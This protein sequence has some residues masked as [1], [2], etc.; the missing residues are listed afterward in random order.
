MDY[1][2]VYNQI[3]D[4]RQ[5][6]DRDLIQLLL[7]VCGER[8]ST[9][10]WCSIDGA[11][12]CLFLLSKNECLA[13]LNG[14]ESSSLAGGAFE[15]KSNL[16]GSLCLLSEDGLGLTSETFLLGIISSLTLSNSRGLTGLVLGNLVNG[17]FVAFRAVSS[18][19]FGSVYLKT[20]LDKL[21]V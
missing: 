18:L 17:V 15:L 12:A 10:R 14:A 11:T 7:K 6:K 8:N 1:K 21:N 5:E 20:S 4:L 19:C 2:L 3:R 9:M 16:L 13:T